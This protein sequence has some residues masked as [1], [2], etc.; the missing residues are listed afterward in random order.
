MATPRPS[1]V[2]ATSER[3]IL[4]V[5][6]RLTVALGAGLTLLADSPRSVRRP[7]LLAAGHAWV[8][9]GLN[10]LRN[11]KIKEKKHLPYSRPL[12]YNT[13]GKIPERGTCCEKMALPLCHTLSSPSHTEEIPC[14]AFVRRSEPPPPPSPSS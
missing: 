12:G 8:P 10:L 6:A 2:H 11:Q 9:G 14:P 7:L 4:S 3:S 5:S 1:V 13:G